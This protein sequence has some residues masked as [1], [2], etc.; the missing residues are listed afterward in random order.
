[1][2]ETI[3]HLIKPSLPRE[4]REVSACDTDMRS[5]DGAAFATLGKLAAS[6]HGPG[7]ELGRTFWIFAAVACLAYSLSKS[8]LRDT[9]S[10]GDKKCPEYKLFGVKVH[11]EFVK[12]RES[13]IEFYLQ[14]FLRLCY[15]DPPPFSTFAGICAKTLMSFAFGFFSCP[16]FLFK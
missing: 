6:F 14:I 10:V 2:D 5:A 13:G 8:L 7:L 3:P 1:M 4:T 12:A 11:L 15:Q 9:F 16:M